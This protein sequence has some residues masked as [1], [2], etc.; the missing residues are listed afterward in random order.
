MFDFFEIKNF[1]CFESLK[2]TGLSRVNLLVGRNAVGKTALLESLFITSGATPELAFRVKGFR[3]L[4]RFEI[5]TEQTAY[6]ILWKD[7]FF[8]FDEA[9]HIRIVLGKGATEL[10]SLDISYTSPQG[11]LFPHAKSS[12][13]TDTVPIVPIAFRWQTS[14]GQEGLAEPQFVKEGFRVA[15]APGIPLLPAV[16]FSSANPPSPEEAAGWLSQLS[17]QGADREIVE[18]VRGVFRDVEDLSIQV[19]GGAPAIYATVRHLKEKISI[20]LIS[21]GLPKLVAITLAII[22]KK[23]GLLY[24]DEIENG[25]HHE[26]LVS[27]WKLISGLA[28]KY[29]VQVFASTHSAECLEAA[30]RS[31]AEP[32]SSLVLLK[33]ERVDG[34]SIVKRFSGEAL[35]SAMIDG[36]EVR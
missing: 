14:S 3:G 11:I 4:P 8:G 1:R 15:P 21:S 9:R 30:T 27:V 16:F 10:R 7:L 20:N 19:I 17:I 31:I 34:T 33:L 18:A 23:G 12:L 29:D 24:V 36:V 25:F 5:S 35:R 6:R 28:E 2:V 32:R 13:S 22:Q 26:A